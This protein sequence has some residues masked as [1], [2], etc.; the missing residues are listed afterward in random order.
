MHLAEPA[1][2]VEPHDVIGMGMCE[3]GGVETGNPLPQAL[4]AEVGSRIDD[5]MALGCADKKRG[6]GAVIPG[7]RGT[8]DST[9][10]PYDRN[11]LGCAGSEKGEIQ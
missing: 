4:D 6:A 8:A 2:I 7:I 9:V 10:A 3:K 1:H 5:E 11:P